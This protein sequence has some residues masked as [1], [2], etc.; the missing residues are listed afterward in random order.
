[1]LK[2]QSLIFFILTLSILSNYAVKA[3]DEIEEHQ[4]LSL[5]GKIAFIAML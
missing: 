1:M 3:V 5:E 4:K 2:V